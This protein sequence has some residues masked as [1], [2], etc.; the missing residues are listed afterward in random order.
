MYVWWPLRINFCTLAILLEFTIHVENICTRNASLQLPLVLEGANLVLEGAN[1]R[2]VRRWEPC[3]DNKGLQC[4]VK[5]NVTAASPIYHT[6][7]F[8]YLVIHYAR[9]RCQSQLSPWCQSNTFLLQPLN[10][11]DIEGVSGISV[12]KEDEVNRRVD[13]QIKDPAKEVNIKYQYEHI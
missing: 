11:C 4:L 6:F 5:T 13:I 9:L 12:S 3:K 8:H 7:L 1:F 2:C 10:L